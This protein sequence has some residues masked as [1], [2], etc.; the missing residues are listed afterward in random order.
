MRSGGYRALVAP[1]DAAISAQPPSNQPPCASYTVCDGGRLAGAG[2]VESCQHADGAEHPKYAGTADPGL[3]GSCADRI[4]LWLSSA[5]EREQ[6]AAI[7]ADRIS[8]LE[9]PRTKN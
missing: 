8:T 7:V 1:A 5:A 6:L 9:P 3:C 2:G 4:S